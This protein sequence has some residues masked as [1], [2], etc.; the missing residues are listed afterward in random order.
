[1]S[2]V[3]R[4]PGAAAIAAALL[5]KRHMHESG[6][7][8]EPSKIHSNHYSHGFYC[9]NR[10]RIPQNKSLHQKET[11][12]LSLTLNLSHSLSLSHTCIHT[13]TQRESSALQRHTWCTN[14][15]LMSLEQMRL[16]LH[17]GEWDL[18]NRTDH[19]QA[20]LPLRTSLNPAIRARTISCVHV[21]AE[22][23]LVLNSRKKRHTESL[24]VSKLGNI[25]YVDKKITKYL[26]ILKALNPWSGKPL[27]GKTNKAKK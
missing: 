4:N 21:F 2:F 6:I 14:K 22:L 23:E 19:M 3:N 7:S 9:M 12:S 8:A 5:C 20:G 15:V 11:I 27:I 24:F 13:H 25:I 17:R 1:L 26:M 16:L 18:L 10:P